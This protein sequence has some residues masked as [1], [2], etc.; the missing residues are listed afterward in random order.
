V[1]DCLQGDEISNL[2]DRLEQERDAAYEQRDEHFQALQRERKA[3]GRLM[4]RLRDVLDEE[5]AW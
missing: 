3:R 1:T 4:R 2:I 5:E